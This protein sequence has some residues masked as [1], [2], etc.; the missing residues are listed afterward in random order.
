MYEPVWMGQVSVAEGVVGVEVEVWDDVAR[1]STKQTKDTPAL[2]ARLPSS[3]L[4]ML[5]ESWRPTLFRPH[6]T[7]PSRTFLLRKI[8]QS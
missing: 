6:L 2:Q 1:T 7:S 8:H 3:S 4:L 5:H